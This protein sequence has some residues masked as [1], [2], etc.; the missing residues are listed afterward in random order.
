MKSPLIL[1]FCKPSYR[2]IDNFINKFTSKLSYILFGT[3]SSIYYSVLDK[4]LSFP[5]YANQEILVLHDLFSKITEF[6][7]FEIEFLHKLS[8]NIPHIA[9]INPAGVSAYLNVKIV[10]VVTHNPRPYCISNRYIFHSCMP[11]LYI[12]IKDII[13][14][15]QSLNNNLLSNRTD[16]HNFISSDYHD[17]PFTYLTNHHPDFDRAITVDKL[18]D[19][20]TNLYIQANSDKLPI[21]WSC[22][23][24]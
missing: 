23:D 9:H 24:W 17:N 19:H 7:Q 1:T 3:E 12:V 13:K 16:T 20:A 22:Q 11:H 6:D 18:I 2:R 14:Y 8:Y 5:N 21:S 4:S 15:T 10:I